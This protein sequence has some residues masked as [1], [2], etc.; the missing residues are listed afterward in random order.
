MAFLSIDDAFELLLASAPSARRRLD[1]VQN[2]TAHGV[3]SYLI[4]ILIFYNHVSDLLGVVLQSMH[5]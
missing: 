5:V 3:G 2:A 1:L 4:E